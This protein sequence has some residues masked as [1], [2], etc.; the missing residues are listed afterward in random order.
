MNKTTA[1]TVLA[2]PAVVVCARYFADSISYG[3]AIHQTGQWSVGF[4]MAALALTP[5]RNVLRSS[6]W[7]LSVSRH[8]R[9]IG[10][11]SFSYAALHTAFYLE[12]KWGADLIIKEGLEPSL[13]SGWLALAIFTVLALSSN[14]FSVRIL[15]RMW[16]RLHRGVYA[17]TFLT[18]VHWWLASFDPTSAF[19][20]AGVLLAVQLLRL[21]P[22]RN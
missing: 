4:L 9:A 7:L 1:W 12:R 21:R 3:Q 2:I 10:V 11:A 15:Q 16:K 18:F 5:L 13:A 8:R 20:T 6:A 17:A 19:V 14:D 22:A